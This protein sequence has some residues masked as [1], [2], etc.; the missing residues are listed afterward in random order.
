MTP[1]QEFK[2]NM[3]FIITNFLSIAI[4]FISVFLPHVRI[5]VPPPELYFYIYG[6]LQLINGG[7]EGLLAF[8]IAT[9][10]I[11]FHKRKGVIIFQIIGIA[12]LLINIILTSLTLS[13]EIGFIIAIISL[14][15][16]VVNL[17]LMI[18]IPVVSKERVSKE[19]KDEKLISRESMEGSFEKVGERREVYQPEDQTLVT[20][21]PREIDSERFERVSTKADFPERWA[22]MYGKK[23]KEKENFRFFKEVELDIQ[24]TLYHPSF[25]HLNLLDFLENLNYR[26]EVNNPP[27]NDTN[28][29]LTSTILDGSIKASI[30]TSRKLSGAGGKLILLILGAIF[31]A[32]SI[33]LL[34]LLQFSFFLVFLAISLILLLAYI[35][36]LIIGKKSTQKG[37]SS[38]YVLER[39]ISYTGMKAV[40]KKLGETTETQ[41][42]PLIATQMKISIA[43]AEKLMNLEQIKEDIEKLSNKIE[44]LYKSIQ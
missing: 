16:F 12:L 22:L 8:L 30:R 36:S 28:S 17:I 13:L 11:F 20:T 38:L 29:Y 44:G 2:R 35:I 34:L 14:C 7:L 21:T 33:V 42:M 19:K 26:I 40:E 10:L 32:L 24:P 23:P 5:H 3:I 39:G 1:K 31:L 37:Y 27:V 15:G 41:K 9:I 18:K 43:G 25:F 6:W 4:L